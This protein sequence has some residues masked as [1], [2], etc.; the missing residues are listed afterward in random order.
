MK[1]LFATLSTIVTFA[2]PLPLHAETDKC[3]GFFK[4]QE[5]GKALQHCRIAAT[6]GSPEAAWLM[7]QMASQGLG[8]EP[9]S[10]EAMHWFRIAADA[11][12]AD[13]Q[14]NLA[15][16][17]DTGQGGSE[18]NQAAVGW[19]RKAADQNHVHAQH[20]LAL[21]YA[22]GEGIEQDYQEAL[23]W[24]HKAAENGLA[25]AQFLLGQMYRT[26]GK[27]MPA[28]AEQ[29]LGW[30][31]K[32]GEQDHLKSQLALA[33]TYAKGIGVDVQPDVAMDWSRRAA[34]L[35]SARAQFLLG[36]LHMRFG[37]DQQ[38]FQDS[39]AWLTVAVASGID[40]AM[41]PLRE[42][43]SLL[44]QDEFMEAQKSAQAIIATV[45]RQHRSLQ[46]F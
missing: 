8:T 9:D 2:Y 10:S 40:E 16:M 13:S 46:G 42:V 3:H 32:A 14:Y 38:D 30:F 21:M 7:G 11:G 12:H 39:A 19:Y 24:T 36:A 43:T 29:S 33:L 27:L 45:Q 17:L 15:V 5:H 22:N 4:K 20:N 44:S 23:K 31:T 18:D 26:G 28:D 25:E 34:F 37:K 6:D 41:G 1:R 35:G